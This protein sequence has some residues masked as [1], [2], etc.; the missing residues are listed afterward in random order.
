MSTNQWH[1]FLALYTHIQFRLRSFSISI[2][3]AISFNTHT[4]IVALCFVF[5]FTKDKLLT[6]FI[7]PS[8]F[9]NF[10]PSNRKEKNTQANEMQTIERIKSALRL[11]WTLRIGFLILLLLF[12]PQNNNGYYAGDNIWKKSINYLWNRRTFT[13]WKE[14]RKKWKQSS[15]GRLSYGYFVILQLYL[16][17]SQMLMFTG[18]R[19]AFYLSFTFFIT[20]L[21]IY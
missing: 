15:F 12:F 13:E 2:S 4:P 10:E 14:W 20:L 1:T 18:K 9:L 11:R 16:E 5:V 6:T 19:E 21:V 8:Y 17:V 3:I 7:R